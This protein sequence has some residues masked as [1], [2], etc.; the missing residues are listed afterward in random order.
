MAES[1]KRLV[2]KSE[3]LRELYLKS[4]NQCAFPGCNHFI[5]NEQGVFIAQLC[6]IEAALSG[7]QRFNPDQT[8]EERRGYNNLI[9]LCHAHH[10]ITDD[11][12][13]FSVERLIEIKTKHEA[14]FA[15]I[16][17]KIVANIVDQT[18]LHE[19]IEPKSLKKLHDVLNWGLSPDQQSENVS[20]FIE[21]SSR[22]Y[23]LPRQTRQ[24]LEIM[25]NRN[26]GRDI[27]GIAVYISEIETATDCEPE[28]LL[29]QLKILENY[30][31]IKEL[32]SS[33][34]GTPITVIRDLASGWPIWESLIEFSLKT[35]NSLYDIIVNLNLS[36]LD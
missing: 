33:E 12:K 31:F 20:E 32:D 3:V 30:G 19:I 18:T 26:H 29:G 8:N 23:K 5:I 17:D 14:Q 34:Y 16:E 24:L 27:G 13:E 2:P 25:A 4:G 21:F 35:G 7:G 28:Y 1:L 6:H 36:L 10:K 11:E 22:L 15:N 9:L